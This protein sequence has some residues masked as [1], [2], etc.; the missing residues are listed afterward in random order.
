MAELK[1]QKNFGYVCKFIAGIKEYRKSFIPDPTANGTIPR[2][3]L[4]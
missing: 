4:D 1:T 2:P 3:R